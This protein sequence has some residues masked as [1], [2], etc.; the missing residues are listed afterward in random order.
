MEIERIC[1][2]TILHATKFV[3]TLQGSGGLQ[4]N[5][6]KRRCWPF[7][8]TFYK[9]FWKSKERSGTSL[10][11]L[12]SVWFLKK[13]IT[14]II[15]FI[16]WTNLIVWLLLLSGILGYM[17]IVIICCPVCDIT[18]FGINLNLFIKCQDK[19]VNISRT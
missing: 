3:F 5:I 13:N 8:F 18:N 10:P 12:F 7:D 15:F 16:N 1:R 19:N 4:K 17:C 9:A 6:L 2:W 11:V 14:H